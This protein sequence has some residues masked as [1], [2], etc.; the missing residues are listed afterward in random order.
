M[1][2]VNLAPKWLELEMGKSSTSFKFLVFPLEI[3]FE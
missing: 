3:R 2:G 1:G